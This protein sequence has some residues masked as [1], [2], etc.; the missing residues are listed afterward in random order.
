MFL[1]GDSAGRNIAHYVAVRAL[2]SK[3]LEVKINGLLLIH[4]YFGSE[5]RT[6]KE[7]ADG[8][9]EHVAMNDLFWRLSIP[10]GS[11]SNYF[12]CNFETQDMSTEEWC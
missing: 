11:N 7:M 5:K 8:V 10:E 4:P 9:G 6:P 12:G 2:W 1:S 3:A